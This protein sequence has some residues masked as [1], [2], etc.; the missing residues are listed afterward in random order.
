MGH[1]FSRVGW[2]VGLSLVCAAGAYA[3]RLQGTV[4]SSSQWHSGWI[5]LATMTDFKAGDRLRLNIGGSA[6]KIVVRLLSRGVDPNT[7]AGIEGDVVSVPENRIVDLILQQDHKDIVQVS[8][9]G[10]PN[11]WGL[12]PLGGG[13]GPATLLSLERLSSTAPKE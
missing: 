12:F 2:L 3:E 8:V 10:G 11:P 7:S 9:H 6:T 1:R 13:N 5:D 4:G